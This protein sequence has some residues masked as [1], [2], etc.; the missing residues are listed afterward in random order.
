M[1]ATPFISELVTQKLG[2]DPPLQ[3]FLAGLQHEINSALTIAQSNLE[4]LSQDLQW[5]E[6]DDGAK[7]RLH[8]DID[9][10]QSGLNRLNTVMLTLNAV[11]DNSHQSRQPCNLLTALQLSIDSQKQRLNKLAIQITLN[12][13]AVAIHHGQPLPQQ[14]LSAIG[15]DATMVQL[16]WTILLKN[17]IDAYAVMID[18]PP[19]AKL[20]KL[21]L[22]QQQQ[23]VD[24]RISSCTAPQAIIDINELLQPFS[25]LRKHAGLGFSLYAANT[26]LANYQSRLKIERDASWLTFSFA[27]PCRAP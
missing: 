1:P 21:A 12:G 5:L 17:A 4:I 27:L 20:I 19:K 6:A 23:T 22:T 24:C 14:P 11:C 7:E 8:V 16:I 26:I 15:A 18:P 9:A 10:A 25:H 3:H 13:A 2:G